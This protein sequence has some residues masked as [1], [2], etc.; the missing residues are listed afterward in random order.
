MRVG[1][2][3]SFCG[4]LLTAAALL[5]VG[6]AT[7]GRQLSTVAATLGRTDVGGSTTN[8]AV[9]HLDVSGPYVQS[10]AASVVKMTGYVRGGGSSEQIRAVIYADSGGQP[11][12]LVGVSDPTTIAAGQSAGWVDFSFG[13]P[14]LLAG[15]SYW[16]GYWYSASSAFEYYT[17]VTGA[18][19]YRSAAYSPASDPPASFGSATT[20]NGSFS[21]YATLGSAPCQTPPAGAITFES[22]GYTT[23]SIN[24]QN[25]WSETGPYDVAVASVAG[26]ANAADFCFGDQ[27]LRLSNATTSGSFADQTF[28]PSV[29]HPAGESTGYSHFDASFRI[30][31]TKAAQQPGLFLS[32]SP[33]DGAGGRMSYVGFDDQADGVHVIFYDVQQPGACMPAG[34][35][36]F[37]S[38][39]VATID[40]TTAHSIRFA[41]DFKPGPGNDVVKLYVDG[42]LKVTGTSWEDYYRY[43]PE[44]AGGGNVVPTTSTLLFREGGTA[45]P[46]TSGN[47]YLV[48]EVAMGSSNVAATLG[49]TDVGGSTTNGAVNHLDVSVRMCSR[50]LRRW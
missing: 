39:D 28:A 5:L 43:D 25:G 20:S 7:A 33:D 46:S 27:A 3:A 34:C 32:V 2:V 8:G 48:D 42:A 1:R 21:L 40:R 36:N 10:S 19:R 4:A 15:G 22:P 6:S 9:N 18:S 44:Q 45:A 23:G 35:A 11:G 26:F 13:S 12:S 50:L 37:V 17:P 29:S 14:P 38:Q 16:L 30:G 41:I 47:G 31:S 24:G 49:R